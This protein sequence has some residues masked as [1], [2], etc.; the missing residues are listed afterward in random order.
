VIAAT[1]AFA[2]FGGKIGSFSA[3]NVESE[4]VLGKEKVSG[5]KCVKKEV[6]TSMAVMGQTLKNKLTIWESDQFE[7]PLRTMVEDGGIMEMRDIDTDKP[8]KKLFRPMPGYK[9]VDNLMAAMGMDFDIT[10]TQMA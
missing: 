6:I 2:L 5:Y 1:P 8:S 7:M 3:D 4:K 9:K 10:V